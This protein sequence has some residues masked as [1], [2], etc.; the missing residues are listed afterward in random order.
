MRRLALLLSTAVALL[1]AQKKDEEPPT[2]VLELPAEP[3]LT[4]KAET[5]RLVFRV[6]P[7]TSKG[8]LS[9]QTRDALNYL[10]K[11]DRAGI[12]KLRAFV[13]GSGDLRRV[14][15]IA[16]EMFTKKRRPLPALTVV[17]VGAL[18]MRGA[19]VL[20]E[21]VA[22]DP[23]RRHNPDGLAFVSGQV[24]MVNQP[25]EAVRPLAEKSLT[26]LE[27]AF[28]AAGVVP[29][30]ALRITCLTSAVDGI[31]Y[32]R[33][34]LYRDYRGAAIAVV[35][36]TREP[37]RTMVACEAVGRLAKAPAKSVVYVEPQDSGL[38]QVA[39]VNARELVFTGSQLAFG[40]REEDARLAFE[41]LGRALEQAGTSYDRIVFAGAY[42][43]TWP[44]A[45]LIAKV[46]PEF[47]PS[48]GAPPPSGTMV[49]FE[50]LPS[51]DAPFALEAIA[52]VPDR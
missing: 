48:R 24:A 4:V 6:S 12:V 51:F 34:R 50:G 38:S 25:Y 39:L 28:E 7:L 26:D 14:Q 41:R 29:E 33:E 30:N 10:M 42:P 21:S 9:S 5:S 2:Q 16:S 1:P 8:L 47:Y 37:T 18:P 49:A 11:Q 17:Q 27:S 35:Q 23:R 19:Q 32:L 46:R 31:D 52:A 22:E 13:A 20:I 40:T 15:A 3:P 43:L 45:A 36:Q 44:V